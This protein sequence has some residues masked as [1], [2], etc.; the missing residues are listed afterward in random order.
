[1]SAVIAA[2]YPKLCESNT[3]I[4]RRCGKS[5]R[6]CWFE[7]TVSD[8]TTGGRFTLENFIQNVVNNGAENQ[9]VQA[10]YLTQQ[11]IDDWLASGGLATNNNG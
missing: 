10:G 1:M 2:L 8:A 3:I 9:A 7:N 5:Q 11:R 4:R 6:R